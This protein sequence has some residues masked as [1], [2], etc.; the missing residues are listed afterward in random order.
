[1]TVSFDWMGRNSGPSMTASST[2]ARH[3]ARDSGVTLVISSRV[4]DWRAKGGGF[5]GKGCVGE[6]VFA[7]DVA[8][9]HGPL[10]DLEQ[11]LAGE[12]LEQEDEAGL[13][14]LCDGGHVF[15]VTPDGD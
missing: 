3:S 13:G 4:I 10:F 14:G 11:G 8:L 1:M 5:T 6:V 9:G 2:I 15:A 12:P 7:R